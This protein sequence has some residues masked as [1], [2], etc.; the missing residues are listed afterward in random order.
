[1]VSINYVLIRAC[2]AIAD[3]AISKSEMWL[4]FL[5]VGFSFYIKRVLFK[6][7]HTCF[8]DIVRMMFV[9]FSWLGRVAG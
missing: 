8:I 3:S 9:V 6:V 4:V 5:I 2:S 7:S 1:M